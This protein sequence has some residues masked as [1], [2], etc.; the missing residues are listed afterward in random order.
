MSLPR[1]DML[2]VLS[3]ALAAFAF[4]L[5]ICN[6]LYSGGDADAAIELTCPTDNTE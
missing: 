6:L 5:A 2:S 3:V 4:G 1:S